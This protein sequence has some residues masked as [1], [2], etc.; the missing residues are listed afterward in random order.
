MIAV[1]E[2]MA[3][4]NE[5]IELTERAVTLEGAISIATEVAQEP[6]PTSDWWWGFLP[7]R[8]R[9]IKVWNSA[10]TLLELAP[11]E[12]D[13]AKNDLRK[14]VEQLRERYGLSYSYSELPDGILAS[15][16]WI[17]TDEVFAEAVG[18]RK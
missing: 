7:S 14:V 11:T 2:I 4:F 17:G 12:I 18:R 13:S 16:Y 6:P 9:A 1:N 3:L 5:A 15:L 10:K 8:R